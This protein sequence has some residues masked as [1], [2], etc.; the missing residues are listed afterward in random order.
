MKGALSLLPLIV[1]LASGDIVRE[2]WVTTDSCTDCGMS[3]LGM[4]SVKVRMLND[5]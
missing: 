1:A 4:L 3:A 2:I 5:L